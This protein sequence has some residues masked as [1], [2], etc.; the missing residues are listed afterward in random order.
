[1]TAGP[2][3]LILGHETKIMG[4]I[5]LTPD[6]FSHDGILIKSTTGVSSRALLFA[7][8]LIKEGADLID[9]GGESSRPGAKPISIEEELKRV[10]PVVK[11]LAKKITVPISVDTYKNEV[12]Q[13][14]LENG[15]TIINNIMGT[16]P[17]KNLL[18]MVKNYD[19]AIV[20]MHMRG[21]PRSMQ[22]NIYYK[23]L[24]MKIIDSL[25]SAIEKCLEIG[26]KSDK[27]IIDPGIGFGKTLEQNCEIIQRLRE[28]AALQ[29]PLL[30]GTSRKS[31]IGKILDKDVHHRLYG[32]L[33]SIGVSIFNGAHIIRAHDV[34]AVKETALVIDAIIKKNH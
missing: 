3:T 1:M 27:I 11:T 16:K 12:A 10:L 30:I 6:S 34:E 26:I 25:K 33:A 23:N 29:Q 31:F 19:A 17:Q 24:I 21:T 15:A 18:R 13:A 32:T 22:K 8:Q 7:Q 2:H 28:F 5:N 9:V 4:V 20:L 14:A